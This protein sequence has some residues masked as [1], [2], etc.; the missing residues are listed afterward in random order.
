MPP[1]VPA[2]KPVPPLATGKVWI[3]AGAPAPPE[4]RIYPAVLAPVYA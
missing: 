3:N 4:V 1:D 2:V